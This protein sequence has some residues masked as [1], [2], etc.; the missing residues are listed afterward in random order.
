MAI[1]FTN[2][3]CKTLQKLTQIGIFGV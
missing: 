2:I 3:H 1:E